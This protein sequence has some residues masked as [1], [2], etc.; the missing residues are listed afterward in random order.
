MR[1]AREFGLVDVG[2]KPLH[3]IVAGVHLHEQGRVLADGAL[4]VLRVGAVGG[5]HFHQARA[6]RGHHIGHAE[7]AADLH[8][9]AARDDHL[10]VTCQ[11]RDREQHRA[12]V[13]VDD[14]GR[15]GAGERAQQLLDEA[16]ALAAAAALQVV[17]EVVGAGHHRKRVLQG[18]IGQQRAAEVGVD[19]G[20][21]EVEYRAQSRLEADL[22]RALERVAQR[23]QCDGVARELARA[24]LRALRL[25]QGPRFSRHERVAV[26]AQQ[27]RHLRLAQQ[28]VNGGQVFGLGERV[29][30]SALSVFAPGRLKSN[31]RYGGQRGCLRGLGTVDDGFGGPRH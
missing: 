23:R 3:G 13:V 12:G 16:V 28:A 10:L 17:F 8:Q 6:G 25:E 7:S 27:G 5:A 2:G 24:R 31:G 20:A 21:G 30:G 26:L 29:A 14:G 9:L 15:L 19:D 11:R 18:R 1:D 4:V 22:H